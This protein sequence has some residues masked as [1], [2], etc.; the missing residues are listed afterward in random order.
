M[1][2]IFY[3]KIINVLAF[4]ANIE[5][6][7][8]IEKKNYAKVCYPKEYVIHSVIARVRLGQCFG[9]RFQFIRRVRRG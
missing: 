9:S 2:V 8:L 4:T 3:Y 6:K 5:E 1:K 7:T